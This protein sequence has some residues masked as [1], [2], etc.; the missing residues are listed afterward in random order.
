MSSQYCSTFS[1]G[2]RYA[3]GSARRSFAAEDLSHSAFPTVRNKIQDTQINK[4]QQQQ[5]RTEATRS[6]QNK[7]TPIYKNRIYYK[8]NPQEAR[9]TKSRGQD[10]AD[11][12]AAPSDGG[13]QFPEDKC[14]RHEKHAP[15][16]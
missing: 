4:R 13:N 2:Q 1:Q 10:D 5:Q 9:T 3:E 11:F 16:T 6:N 7:A 15:N 14:V 12:G 8:K